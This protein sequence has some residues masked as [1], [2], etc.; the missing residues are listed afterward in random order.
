MLWH[1]QWGQIIHELTRRKYVQLL[2]TGKELHQVD[3]LS[4]QHDYSF[5]GSADIQIHTI[6]WTTLKLRTTYFSGS[7]SWGLG[8]FANEKEASSSSLD[9]C[10]TTG[11]QMY[12]HRALYVLSMAAVL[13]RVHSVRGV[14][15]FVRGHGIN[16]SIPFQLRK[17][18]MPRTIKIRVQSS[19]PKL[20]AQVPKPDVPQD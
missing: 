1:D 20:Q 17:Y 16:A 12:Q 10:A 7:E 8:G 9:G 3:C 18:A 15:S 5:G 6:S 4:K 13:M 14:Q 2:G 19:R 11:P